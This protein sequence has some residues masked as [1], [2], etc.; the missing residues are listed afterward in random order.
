MQKDDEAAAKAFVKVNQEQ[1]KLWNRRKDLFR[2][3]KV[4]YRLTRIGQE[5]NNYFTE[6]EQLQKLTHKVDKRI[7]KTEFSKDVIRRTD[8][9]RYQLEQHRDAILQHR[10]NIET[11]LARLFNLKITMWRL[12]PLFM[13]VKVLET[14]RQQQTNSRLLTLM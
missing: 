3:L 13:M 14:Q 5:L 6:E 11:E 7:K 4:N 10:T 8:E 2:L 12:S 1:S 9:N